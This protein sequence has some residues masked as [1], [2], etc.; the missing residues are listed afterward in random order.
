V[1]GLPI[2]IAAGLLS[3]GLFLALRSARP[4]RA[5]SA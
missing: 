4:V 2:L 1:P 5:A 3:F